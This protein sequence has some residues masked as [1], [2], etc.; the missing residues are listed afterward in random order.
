MRRIKSVLFLVFIFYSL[1]GVAREDLKIVITAAFVSER[2]LPVYQELAD[3]ISRKANM[4]VDIISELSYRHS[5]LL[6]DK[7]IIQLGF[8]CGLPYTHKKATGQQVLLAMPIVA[9]IKDDFEKVAGF[10]RTPGKY[11]SYT[12]VHK[13]A[14][15]KNWAMLKG[16]SYAYNDQD[17][18][19]GY[20]MPRYKLIQ[21]GAKSWEDYFSKILV[22]GSHEESIRMVAEGVVDA[23][24]VDSLVLDFDRYLKE[25]NAMKVKIIEVLFAG[26]A[27]VPP[28]VMSTRTPVKLRKKLQLI[29]LNMHRDKEGKKI[30]KKALLKRFE[31]PDDKNYD[32]IRMMEKAAKDA[33][34]R[35]FIE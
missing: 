35:D 30:L 29:F 26:G 12:I 3:Y 17:S 1:V 28:V 33:G 16:K 24:S 8:V 18:N 22:S 13:D 2:G 19:S 31:K 5:S 34:F 9:D 10:K 27:G 15:I 23:S 14:D 25:E 21:L 32:D 7:G 11:Y 20:N 6:L 4:D